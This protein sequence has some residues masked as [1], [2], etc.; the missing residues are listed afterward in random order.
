MCEAAAFIESTTSNTC[1]R[2]RNSD[3][4]KAAATIES[5]L[6]NTCHRI[7]NTDGGKAA[8]IQVFAT[9]CVSNGFD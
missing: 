5:T 2:I 1:H 7:R 3:G 6:S 8:A 4:G 9:Y